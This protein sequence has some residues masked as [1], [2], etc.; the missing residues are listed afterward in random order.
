MSSYPD[1]KIEQQIIRNAPLL[2]FYLKVNA[3]VMTD[4]IPKPLAIHPSARLVLN[5]WFLEDPWQTTGFGSPEPTGITYLAAEVTGP[6]GHTSDG[7]NRF[8]GRY[9]LHHWGNSA[10]ARAYAR[11]ASGLA[12]DSGE[13]LVQTDGSSVD[14]R[15]SI[16]GRQVVTA[17]A[18]ISCDPGATRSGYSVYYGDRT[19]N[20]ER[21]IARF[22]IPWVAD[23]HTVKDAHV[24]FS[25]DS[26]SPLLGLVNNGPQQIEF[27]SFRR[28]TLVP[29]LAN[30]ALRVPVN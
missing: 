25:F 27:A 8:P 19:S 13:T 28:M 20:G 11:R 9:W 2:S 16:D 24:E 10:A 5:M 29:Y 7:E 22:Q 30:G 6:E 3:D 12:I 1:L 14:A 17:D 23:A 26:G 21:E 15:L 18:L 4:R